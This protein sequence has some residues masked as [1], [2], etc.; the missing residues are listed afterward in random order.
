MDV[1]ASDVMH[2]GFLVVNILGT[3]NIIYDKLVLK[4][5]HLKMLCVEHS[6][7]GHIS[8][9]SLSETGLVCSS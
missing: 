2:V 6:G 8:H 5:N 7:R 4:K 3:H 1:W 9:F